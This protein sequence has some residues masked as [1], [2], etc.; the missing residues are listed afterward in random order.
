MTK[1]HLLRPLE[2]AEDVAEVL[3][4][5]HAG[6]ERLRNLHAEAVLD[7]PREA[8]GAA[9]LTQL[10]DD[11]HDGCAL[12]DALRSKVANKRHAA[13]KVGPVL[14]RRRSRADP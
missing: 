8:H 7:E 1:L 5:N 6:K 12:H 4:V 2:A 14:V 11:A 3:L 10:A 9:Q 13:E